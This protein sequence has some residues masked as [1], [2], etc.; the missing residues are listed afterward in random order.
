MQQLHTHDTHQ[1]HLYWFKGII[2]CIKCGSY[3]DTTSGRNVGLAR[4]C[5]VKEGE[6]KYRRSFLSRM[7]RNLPPRVYTGSPCQE[8]S[9]FPP[10]YRV[11]LGFTR[12]C[13]EKPVVPLSKID[14]NRSMSWLFFLWKV[15]RGRTPIVLWP[16]LQPSRLPQVWAHLLYM[17]AR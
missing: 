11:F 5:Q 17:S 9:C 3:T 1:R 8:I 14:R 4:K 10:V 16:P 2:Y 7:G 13:I 12:G 15:S 6:D